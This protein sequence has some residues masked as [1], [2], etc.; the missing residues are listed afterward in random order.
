MMEQFIQGFENEFVI[1]KLFLEDLEL[2]RTFNKF[3][4]S[5]F[6]HVL[7]KGTNAIIPEHYLTT[8][9]KYE[10]FMGNIHKKYFQILGASNFFQYLKVL[11]LFIS[12]EFQTSSHHIKASFMDFLFTLNIME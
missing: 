3:F 4:E 12:D 8:Y 11:Q 5:Y 1:V 10:T 2:T 7:E 9:I 6:G